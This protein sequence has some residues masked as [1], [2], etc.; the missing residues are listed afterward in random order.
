[1]LTRSWLPRVRTQVEFLIWY[2]GHQDTS[3]PKKNH[4]I[5]LGRS[6]GTQSSIW[7]QPGGV[8]GVL[9]AGEDV[10]R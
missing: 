8:G 10:G 1:M 5:W 2:R 3:H 6:P 7:R 4:R 9:G